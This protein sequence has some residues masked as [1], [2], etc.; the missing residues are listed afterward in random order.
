MLGLHL[1]TN[2]LKTI[3]ILFVRLMHIITHSGYYCTSLSR[4]VRFLLALICHVVF[5]NK[6]VY[7]QPSVVY[8]SP[9]PQLLTIV[10]TAS[11]GGSVGNLR[12]VI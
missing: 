11:S 9:F 3:Y 10:K 12:I 7:T 2:L 4:G 6:A 8:D 1:T 5:T